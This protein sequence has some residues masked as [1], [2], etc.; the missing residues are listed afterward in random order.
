MLYFFEMVFEHTDNDMYTIAL[1]NLQALQITRCSFLNIIYL[2]L[3]KL[4][5][6]V[7][8]K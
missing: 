3:Y 6:M 7:L 2:L 5:N 4:P 1:P 8:G